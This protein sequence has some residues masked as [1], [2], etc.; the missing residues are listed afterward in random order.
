MTDLTEEPD[1]PTD[2]PEPNQLNHREEARAR[3]GV[4]LPVE[5]H[6]SYEIETH[7]RKHNW[8]V[9]RGGLIGRA[10]I[11]RFCDP[12]DADYHFQD[13]K[14][15]F[16]IERGDRRIAAGTL[17]IWR[18]IYDEDGDGWD[19]EGFVRRGDINSQSEYDMA[20]AVA[21]VWGSDDEE[22][23]WTDDPFCYGHLCS[24]DRLVINAKTS[25]DVEAA[26]QIIDALLKRVRRGMAVMVLKAFPLDYEGGVTAENQPAFERRQRALMR[27]YQ[28]RIGF[29]P[30]P[31]KALADEGWMLRL[32][33]EGARPDVE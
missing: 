28:R 15:F 18:G 26:W 8:S 21:K 10:W 16:V 24:F 2:Q 5:R 27:L 20:V 11:E 30:V 6:L 23:W 1:G 29:E 3:R 33:N 7:H 12:K 4:L 25:A 14:V 17:T 19:L 32:F 9:E 13:R 22:N 31:H